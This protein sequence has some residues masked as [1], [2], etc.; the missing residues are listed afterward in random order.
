M[1]TRNQY[2]EGTKF[3]FSWL[4]LLSLPRSPRPLFLPTR[5]PS[6]LTSTD[7]NFREPN[8]RMLEIFYIPYIV[9][10]GKAH[11]LVHL[12]LV[13][14]GEWNTYHSSYSRKSATGWTPEEVRPGPSPPEFTSDCAQPTPPHQAL[15]SFWEN[16]D[17]GALCDNWSFF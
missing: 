17:K 12:W 8:L 6:E 3:P 9:L 11:A 10:W 7:Q 4:R 13:K 14:N 16:D 15:I 1:A 5:C 2:P